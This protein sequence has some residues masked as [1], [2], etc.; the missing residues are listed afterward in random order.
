MSAL[1]MKR[2]LRVEL[3][4]G[5]HVNVGLLSAGTIDQIYLSLRL[6]VIKEITEEKVPIILDEAFVY[7]DKERMKNILKYLNE[8]CKDYQIII[9]TCSNREKQAME[10]L[11]LEYNHIEI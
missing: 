10:E 9:F 11:K 7:Y 8:Q 6:A 3:S 1:A 4:S 2:G 5:E